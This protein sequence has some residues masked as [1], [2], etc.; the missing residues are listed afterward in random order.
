MAREGV[1]DQ[2][3][4]QYLSAVTLGFAPADLDPLNVANIAN[5][6]AKV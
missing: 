5:A 3:L 6:F 1:D 2:G 4:F